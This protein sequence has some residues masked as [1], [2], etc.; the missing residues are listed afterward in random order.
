MILANA[1]QVGVPSIARPVSYLRS[2][3]LAIPPMLLI[4][5]F[6]EL[7]KPMHR[8]ILENT[9]RISTLVALRDILFPRLISGQLRLPDVE[10]QIAAIAA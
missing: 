8:T 5:R 4:D 9:E 10:N 2:I 3:K 1:S 6:A 7:S